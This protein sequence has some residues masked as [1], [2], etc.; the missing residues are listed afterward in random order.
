MLPIL[1]DENTNTVLC[2]GEKIVEYL[3]KTYCLDND[4][5]EA[6]QAAIE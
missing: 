3:Y 2:G 6:K 5:I 4:L 1:E